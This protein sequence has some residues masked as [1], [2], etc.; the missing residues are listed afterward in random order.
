VLAREA[1]EQICPY[2]HATRNNVPVELE[3][4]GA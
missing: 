4:L 1:H 3:I 2:S